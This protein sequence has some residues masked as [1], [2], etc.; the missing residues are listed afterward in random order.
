MIE[1]YYYISV[2]FTKSIVESG[3]KLSQWHDKEV[4]LNG[5]MKKCVSA[6]L[7]PKDDM[8]KYRS[9]EFICVKLKVNKTFCYAADRF[10]FNLSKNIPEVLDLYIKS[11]IP[12]ENYIFGMYRIPECLV[13]TTVI[14]D[15]ITLLNKRRDSPILFDNSEDLY[16][17]N[18]IQV[19]K[20]K[21]PGFSDAVLYSFYSK[22]AELGRVK[23]VESPGKNTALFIDEDKEEVYSLR[24]PDWL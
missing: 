11:V 17:N 14:G 24:I 20:E 10:L 7:N 9:H 2:N 16:I 22:L 1:V 21:T 5:Q 8:H 19:N 12:V 15:M 4:P 3:L 23:K 18:L 6:L 13:T